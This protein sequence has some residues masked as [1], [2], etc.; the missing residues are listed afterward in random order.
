MRDHVHRTRVLPAPGPAMTSSGPRSDVTTAAWSGSSSSPG[1]LACASP[2][3]AAGPG[4][5]TQLPPDG[6]PTAGA[7]T[8]GSTRGE[9]SASERSFERSGEPRWVPV[10]S[11]DPPGDP[12]STDGT[13]EARL[14][15]GDWRVSPQ[16][17]ECASPQENSAPF[18]LSS[19][20]VEEADRAVYAVVAGVPSDIAA[21]QP[22]DGL[23]DGGRR[24]RGEL[25]QRHVAEDGQFRAEALD[26]G[27]DLGGHRL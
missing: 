15:W 22:G 8:A 18:A 23:H 27:G 3:A 16:E 21:A 19:P 7:P 4:E 24:L 2:G 11:G 20:G 5:P 13:P 25:V 9:A 26:Q 14:V 1:G 10:V 6:A 17:E 12:D